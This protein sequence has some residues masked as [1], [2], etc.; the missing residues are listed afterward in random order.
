M[1]ATRNCDQHCPRV[2]KMKVACSSPHSQVFPESLKKPRDRAIGVIEKFWYDREVCLSLLA[3][4]GLNLLRESAADV[5]LFG[6]L[7]VISREATLM[8]KYSSSH[9]KNLQMGG[10]SRLHIAPAVAKAG[11]GSEEE[12]VGPAHGENA[13]S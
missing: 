12:A 13:V 8:N 6:Q 9:M 11:I 2:E 4:A 10:G 7:N 5:A 3:H 1:T